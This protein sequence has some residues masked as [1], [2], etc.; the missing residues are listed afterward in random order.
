MTEETKTETI[1]VNEGPKQIYLNLPIAGYPHPLTITAQMDD[2]I[3][4]HLAALPEDQQKKMMSTIIMNMLNDA[5]AGL[6]LTVG[7]PAPEEAKEQKSSL[8]LPG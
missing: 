7:V 3:R 5:L 4:L 8:I 2:T 6:G 1:P